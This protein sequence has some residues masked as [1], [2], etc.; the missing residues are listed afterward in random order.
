VLRGS[1]VQITADR[2][3]PLE[4]DGDDAGNST[5]ITVRVLSGAIVVCA[6]AT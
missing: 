6:A 1:R 5:G 3:L 4:Y 2:S